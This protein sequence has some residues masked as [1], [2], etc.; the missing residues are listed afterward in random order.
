[1]ANTSIDNNNLKTR[2]KNEIS[3]RKYTG[4]I[5][6]YAST[7]Y[8]YSTTPANGVVLTT[9]HHNKI[10]TPISAINLHQ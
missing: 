1:M 8:D 5:S 6:S 10:I 9:E 4:S 3:R 2:L 7:T